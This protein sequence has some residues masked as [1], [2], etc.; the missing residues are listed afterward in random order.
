VK[1][2]RLRHWKD[3]GKLQM[4]AMP[5]PAQSKLHAGLLPVELSVE[6]VRPTDLNNHPFPNVWPLLGKL[7]PLAFAPL[8][9]RVFRWRGSQC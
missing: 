3:E 4:G 6:A 7:D 9:D 5:S 1:G 2:P 8:P